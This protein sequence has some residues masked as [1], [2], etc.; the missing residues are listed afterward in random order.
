RHFGTDAEGI[1]SVDRY[2]AYKAMAQVKTGKLILAFC[3]AHVRRDFLV[4][5]T[6]WSE[7]TDWAWSWVEDIGVL[8]QRNDLRLS[9]TEGTPAYAEADRLLRAQ[10]EHL[11]QCCDSELSQST[12]RQPQRKTLTSLSK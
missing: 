3:W 8:Y 12:L 5:L 2:V 6:S 1:V 4:V 11:R 9:L 10:V 7:L